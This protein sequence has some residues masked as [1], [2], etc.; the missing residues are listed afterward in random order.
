MTEREKLMDSINGVLL[1]A[2][3][4]TDEVRSRIYLALEDYEITRGCQ[5]QTRRLKNFKR[6]SIIGTN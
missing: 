1:A 5:Q 4:L 2:G 3:C 6:K